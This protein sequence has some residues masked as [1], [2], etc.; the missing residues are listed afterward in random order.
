MRPGDRLHGRGNDANEVAKDTR[1]RIADTASMHGLVHPTA[2]KVVFQEVEGAVVNLT[3]RIAVEMAP[4]NVTGDAICHGFFLAPLKEEAISSPLWQEHLSA[5]VPMWW[6]GCDRG[7]NALLVFLVR[8]EASS[9]TRTV[10]V[11]DRGHTAT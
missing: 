9:P 1:G 6:N 7:L 10:T 8:D 2:S 11:V 5:M 3:R 4:A